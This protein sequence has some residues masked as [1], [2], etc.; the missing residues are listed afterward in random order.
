MQCMSTVFLSSEQ[1]RYLRQCSVSGVWSSVLLR[2]VVTQLLSE[3]SWTA[4]PA[5]SSLSL[6]ARSCCY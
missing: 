3:A 5:L 1:R 2:L 4:Q 6:G